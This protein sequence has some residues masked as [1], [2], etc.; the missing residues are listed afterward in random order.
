[1]GVTMVNKILKEEENKMQKS[2]E[3]FQH[4]LMTVRSGRATPSLIESLKI[5]YYGTPT[6]LSQIAS[7]HSPDARTLTIS[8]WDKT[9]LQ[10][11]EKALMQS[12]MGFNPSNDGNIIHVPVP[13][14]SEEQRKEYVKIA[15]S[16]AEDTKIA[17]RNI[18]RDGIT[19]LK[20]EEKNKVI[21][22]DDS[23]K[24]QKKIQEITDQNITEIDRI[25]AAKEKEIMEV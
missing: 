9:A 17:I 2:V 16:M 3:H 25:L 14:P 24:G 10:T 12:A 19:K 15:K 7:I 21:S 8:P 11:I 18:R 22:E 20:D 4:D 13:S 23:K 6:P 5:D 1:M